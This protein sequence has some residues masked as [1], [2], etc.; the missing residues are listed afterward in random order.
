M[1]LF[2]RLSKPR[3]ILSGLLCIGVFAA[4]CLLFR[5]CTQKPDNRNEIALTSAVSKTPATTGESQISPGAARNT[6]NWMGHW[7]KADKRYDLVLEM[8]RDFSFLNQDLKV[9]LQFPEQIV[10]TNNKV[11]VAHLIAEMIKHNQFDWDI[12]L[13]G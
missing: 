8:K 2:T 12:V 10:G 4:A 11:V 3:V 6:I 13:A 9:N 5:L 1:R 7:Y